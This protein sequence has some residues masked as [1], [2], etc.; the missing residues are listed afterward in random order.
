[1]ESSQRQA[2]GNRRLRRRALAHFW[3]GIVLCTVGLYSADGLTTAL[4]FV[5]IITALIG[6]AGILVAAWDKKSLPKSTDQG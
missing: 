2:D 3:I 1:M 5:G 6:L 4:L